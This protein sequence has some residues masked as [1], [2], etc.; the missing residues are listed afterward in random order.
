MA[1]L[2]FYRR[3]NR[4]ESMRNPATFV[5]ISL[6]AVGLTTYSVVLHGNEAPSPAAFAVRCGFLA[7]SVFA[8]VVSLV[9]LRKAS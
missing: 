8:L 3:Y 9:R 7:L 6:V 2:A 4:S 1:D 5:F